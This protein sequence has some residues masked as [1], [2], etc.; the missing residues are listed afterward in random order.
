MKPSILT[1]GLLGNVAVPKRGRGGGGSENKYARP[2][3]FASLALVLLDTK[4][5]A[6]G[7]AEGVRPMIALWDETVYP[8]PGFTM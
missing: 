7:G 5:G 1:L 4:A 8:N 3:N 6:T 2:V